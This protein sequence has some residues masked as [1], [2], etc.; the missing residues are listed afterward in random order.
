[1]LCAAAPSSFPPPHP[2]TLLLSFL[3]FRLLLSALGLCVFVCVCVSSVHV[4]F[5][6][7][8]ARTL[9]PRAHGAA[10]AAVV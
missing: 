3:L 5:W 8:D 2:P 7:G 1:M 10:V 4:C 9:S 6:K